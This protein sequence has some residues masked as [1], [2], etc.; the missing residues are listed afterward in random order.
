MGTE[1]TTVRTIAM[2]DTTSEAVT[3]T[4][5]AVT[6]APILDETMGDKK[7]TM[8]GVQTIDPEMTEI[9]VA[10]AMV[11]HETINITIIA[12]DR[13]GKTEIAAAPTITD[14]RRRSGN[15]RC[16][17][18]ET[19]LTPRL[20][21]VPS[22]RRRTTQ[23]TRCST[24]L[25]LRDQLSQMPHPA[26]AATSDACRIPSAQ[27]WT[28]TSRGRQLE[29]GRCRHSCANSADRE[30]TTIGGCNRVAVSR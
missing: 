25:S 30:R 17:R 6:G 18:A 3:V 7:T 23:G 2:G 8:E 15:R 5:A 28:R 27:S 16:G 1:V 11:A 4:T 12:A 21:P 20:R 9:K 13:N 14:E 10:M 24:T 22:R 26:A 29:I 19:S